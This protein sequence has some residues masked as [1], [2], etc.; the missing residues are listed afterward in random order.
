MKRLV[1]TVVIQVLLMIISVLLG[2]IFLQ[3]YEQK[4]GIINI[5]VQIL[6]TFIYSGNIAWIIYNIHLILKGKKL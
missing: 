2:P 3:Y 6:F 1:I 5:P 4:T